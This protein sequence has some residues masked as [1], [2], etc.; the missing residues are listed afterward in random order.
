[1]LLRLLYNMLA[2]VCRCFLLNLAMSVKVNYRRFKYKPTPPILTS[3]LPETH[4]ATPTTKYRRRRALYRGSWLSSA[5]LRPSCIIII[6]III[7]DRRRHTQPLVNQEILDTGCHSARHCLHVCYIRQVQW[8]TKW[9]RARNEVGLRSA[10][11][12]TSCSSIRWNYRVAE[13]WKYELLQP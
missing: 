9:L 4:G 12:D 5:I 11:E 1:M 8:Q 7:M 3:R 13:L 6:I 2:N 10:P